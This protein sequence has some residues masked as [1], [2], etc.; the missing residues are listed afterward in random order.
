MQS[1]KTILFLTGTRADFG[2]LRPLIRIIDDSDAF[3]AKVFVTGMHML[4]LY[5]A[6]LDEVLKQGFTDCAVFENQTLG[7]PMD[8]ILANTILGLSNC[9]SET[10]IDMIV[11]HG[12]RPEALAGAIVGA[13]RNVLVGHVEGGEVSGTIDE[14][15]RHA[16]TKMS[17]CH[18]VANDEAATRLRQLGERPE[19]IFEIGSPDIDVMRSENLPKIQ[20]VKEH[21]DI[22]HFGD[23]A[24]AI[25]H[26][27]TTELGETSKHA[28]QFVEALT[29]SE[30]NYVV[31]YP[32]NDMGAG[33]I[34]AVLEKVLDHPRLRIFPSI[35]FDA[36]LTLLRSA[37]FIVGNSSAGIREAPFYGV[38]TVN[39]G[40][41]QTGRFS[42][43]TIFNCANDTPSIL[44]AIARAKSVAPHPPSDHFGKGD[45]AEKFLGVLLDKKTWE[46]SSQKRF[47]DIPNLTSALGVSLPCPNIVD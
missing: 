1:S 33:E 46:V 6:T 40:S 39:I 45:S 18:F 32:N 20:N 24:L 14:L 44:E 11:V 5:G 43:P 23:F 31:V 19:T 17:H 10:D 37:D 27:V 38:P 47:Q 8:T 16:T 36:F 28:H 26:P 21:Y 3:V 13:F 9:I 4:D 12:D 34:L 42:Y 22:E 30:D 2:K 25:L 29:A 15:I 7:D 41:R 35:R